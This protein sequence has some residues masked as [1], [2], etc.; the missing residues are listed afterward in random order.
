M[1]SH[2]ELLGL[3]TKKVAAQTLGQE[4]SPDEKP[5]TE[6]KPPIEE[7]P[8]IIS[9]PDPLKEIVGEDV[10]G[11][12]SRYK[13]LDERS[14][15]YEEEREV[16]SKQLAEKEE[17]VKQLDITRSTEY[18][19]KIVKPTNRAAATFVEVVGSKEKAKEILATIN[20]AELTDEQRKTKIQTILTETGSESSYKDVK[21]AAYAYID[22][23]ANDTKFKQNWSEMQKKRQ[24][25]LRR[26]QAERQA[27]SIED[28]KKA[29][30]ATKQ[31][32][33]EKA[34]VLASRLGASEEV[35]QKAS[36]EWQSVYDNILSDKPVDMGQ[37]AAYNMIGRIIVG[38]A[39]SLEDA[40]KKAKE[41]A[42]LREKGRPNGGG[43]S[44]VQKEGQQGEEK[45]GL[46]KLGMK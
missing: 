21:D 33:L 29:T 25:D 12:V 8:N 46:A 23:Q 24:E 41:L 13:E 34:K 3:A 45:R 22:T 19:E 44:H 26:A 9:L 40:I 1:P 42:E 32:A 27:R 43:T 39:D 11:F 38:Q 16:L 6:E 17:V 18:Q 15:K 2:A 14:K 31:V 36:D 20:N 35:V 37:E 5:N 28:L 30:I 4:S 7:K 10:T